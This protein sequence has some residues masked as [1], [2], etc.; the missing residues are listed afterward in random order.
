[1]GAARHG[2]RVHKL[3]LGR[4]L[5]GRKPILPA[6]GMNADEAE[7]ARKSPQPAPIG[8][9]YLQSLTGVL[10]NLQ[11]R[12]ESLTDIPK[13]IAVTDG[14]NTHVPSTEPGTPRLVIE[15]FRVTARRVSVVVEYGHLGYSHRAVGAKRS[16]QATLTDKSPMQFYRL[17]FL[18]PE[19]GAE[20]LV[21]AEVIAGGSALPALSAWINQAGRELHGDENLPRLM[22]PALADESRLE[23]LLQGKTVAEIELVRRNKGTDGVPTSSTVRLTEIVKSSSKMDNASALAR[24]WVDR[25]RSDDPYVE[26]E[27]L[28]EVGKLA[29]IVDPNAEKMGFT[30]G[31]VKFKTEN[32]R[33]TTVTP[34][35]AAEI[36]V[37]SISERRPDDTV[38]LDRT[39]G[40]VVAM[41]NSEDLSVVWG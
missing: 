29:E 38:W 15:D 21:A 36:F 31:L 5:N 13:L 22:V 26:A 24:R 25:Q 30:D 8:E 18:V 32:D 39:R 41:A 11:A 20:G 9:D 23:K 33:F 16:D 28:R 12:S 17:E 35:R 7:E 2:F 19:K 37:Y 3:K 40:Q 14:A 34:S 27:R 10:A 1:M 4:G 6:R